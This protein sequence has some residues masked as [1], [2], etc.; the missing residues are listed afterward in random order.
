MND[1]VIYINGLLVPPN[2]FAV[3]AANE[4]NVGRCLR[5]TAPEEAVRDAC[6]GSKKLTSIDV[7]EVRASNFVKR[8][9]YEKSERDDDFERVPPNEDEKLPARVRFRCLG[10]P[11]SF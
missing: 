2:L 11:N 6:N 4:A 3:R 7:M 1:F 5:L 9:R 10:V 8:Y